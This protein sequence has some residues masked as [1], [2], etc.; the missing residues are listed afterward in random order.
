MRKRIIS[1]ILVSVLVMGLSAQE[2]N[3]A[4][5]VSLTPV[6]YIVSLIMQACG[7]D[8]GPSLNTASMIGQMQEVLDTY[9]SSGG[10]LADQE[11]YHAYVEER[12]QAGELGGFMQWRYGDGSVGVRD[13]FFSAVDDVT[14]WCSAT[15]GDTVSL[16]S[17]IGNYWVNAAKGWLG[18]QESYGTDGIDYKI[19]VKSS[20]IS[21]MDGFIYPNLS[22][23][24]ISDY[25]GLLVYPYETSDNCYVFFVAD[26]NENGGLW[27]QLNIVSLAPFSYAQVE[28]NGGLRFFQGSKVT[29]QI[30]NKSYDYY[31]RKFNSSGFGYNSSVLPYYYFPKAVATQYN[32]SS[33]IAKSL[34]L[35]N[36]TDTSESITAKSVN[37]ALQQTVIA[38]KSSSLSLPA[39][40]EEAQ[41]KLQSVDLGGGIDDIIKALTA[42]GLAIDKGIDVPDESETTADDTDKK[43]ITSLGQIIE[44]LEAIPKAI[45]SFFTLDMAAIETAF[46]ELQ[47]V[48]NSKF[49]VLAKLVNI[50]KDTGRTFSETP[51]VFKMQTPDCLRF[52]IHEDYITVL[53]LTG[54]KDLFFWVRGI[55][56]ASIWFAFGKWLL[57]Q[58]DVKFHIG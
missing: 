11:A 44:K 14:S 54:Y 27:G 35:G 5:P 41:E 17:E 37:P 13:Q 32:I 45:A 23:Y 36:V 18:T 52:A 1:L 58:F 34:I 16:G 55:M 9:T 15:W 49:D 6:D 33:E 57:D 43:I 10:D 20:S 28:K 29:T 12:A 40:G 46:K 30:N 42:A 47:S 51:P 24:S 50:F 53:D 4:V 25:D 8:F 19:P 56:A 7:V 48:F 21:F 26:V 38:Q 3:A 2:S 22:F 39:S 31:H